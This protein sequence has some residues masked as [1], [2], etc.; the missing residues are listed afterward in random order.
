MVDFKKKSLSKTYSDM[1]EVIQKKKSILIHEYWG[2][3]EISIIKI[4]DL[5]IG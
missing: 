2:L 5:Q 3:H 1:Y 4:S